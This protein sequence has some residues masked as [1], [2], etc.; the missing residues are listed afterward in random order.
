L[1]KSLF[2]TFT[3]VSLPLTRFFRNEL[4]KYQ[5][6]HINFE[7]MKNKI[8][9]LI[10]G[11]LLTSGSLMAQEFGIKGGV[12]I[13]TSDAVI[14]DN[15][16]QSGA[17][18]Y[19]AGIFA[20]F[21]FAFIGISPELQYSFQT[22]D[23][24]DGGDN[25][26]QESAYLDLPVM[27]RFYLPGG[28]N[29]QLGPQFGYLMSAKQI[30]HSNDDEIDIKDELLNSNISVNLGIGWDLPFGLDVYGR[31]NIGISDVNDPSSVSTAIQN[32][33]IQI[34]LAYSL[35]K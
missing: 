22:I 29:F 14:G 5:S 7:T 12:N 21:K 16:E 32:S 17:S 26:N 4:F 35:K 11:L 20:K 2:F 8:K 28:L 24:N 13:P 18:G 6:I 10:F 31:Y 3:N 25:K 33:M 9:I 23:F 30:T 34:S 19:H 15:L 1:N 27:L